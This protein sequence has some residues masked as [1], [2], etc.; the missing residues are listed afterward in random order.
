LEERESLDASMRQIEFLDSEIG[1]VD[2]LIAS[3]R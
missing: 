3:T 2:R 1:D